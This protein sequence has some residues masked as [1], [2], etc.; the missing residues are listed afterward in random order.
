M[1]T[2]KK[3]NVVFGGWYQ[4]TTL[5]LSEVHRFLLHGTSDLDLDKTRLN[6]LRNGLSLKSVKRVVGSLEYLDI[7][8]KNGIRIKYFEDGLYVLNWRGVD[9]INESVEKRKN[10]L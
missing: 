1:D 4:R 6:S 7:E 2:N 5:H 10:K 9:I 3:I 8:S